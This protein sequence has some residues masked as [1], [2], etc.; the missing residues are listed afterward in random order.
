MG[1]FMGKSVGFDPSV[2]PYVF[3][4]ASC[5]DELHVTCEEAEGAARAGVTVRKAVNAV[6]RSRGWLVDWDVKCP[7]CVTLPPSKGASRGEATAAPSS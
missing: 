2:F 1:E 5:G 3:E 6:R 4:C 7:D